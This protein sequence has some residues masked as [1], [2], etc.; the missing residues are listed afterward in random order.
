MKRYITAIIAGGTIFA[1]SA[2]FAASL[3]GIT[4]DNLGSNDSVVA[5]CDGNGVTTSYATSYSA[6]SA[7][8]LV[9]SVNVGG[10]DNTN[11][12]GQTLSVTL[13]DESD[14]VL[15]QGS[16]DSVANATETVTISPVNPATEVPAEAVE[17]VH[18]VITGT[19]ATP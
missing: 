10:I 15:G 14:A 17:G 16:V 3:G 19:D 4:T 6:T 1:A 13:T 7:A 8:Y 18:V 5:A 2:A 11:C 9:D 12:A